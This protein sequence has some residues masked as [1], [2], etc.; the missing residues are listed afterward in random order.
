MTAE[1]SQD[2]IEAGRGYEEL[3]VPALFAPWTEHLVAAAH[4]GEGSHVLDVACGTGVLARRALA[5]VGVAGRVVGV[6]PAPGMIAV[7]KEIEPRIQWIEC[8]AE[9]LQLED[10]AFDC[11]VSQFG[12]MFFDDRPKAAEEM[13][14]VLKKDG[15]LAVAVW[16]T[17]D[18]NPVY[19]DVVALLQEHVS[20]RAAD[21]LRLP[22]SLGNAEEVFD[23][24]QQAGFAGVQSAT[25]FEKGKFRSARQMVEAEL[26]GW[27]PMFDINLEEDEIETVL[28]ASEKVFN[29]YAAHS[30]EI[31]FTTSAHII[32]A[33]KG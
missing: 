20:N 28:A 10:G 14:R 33:Q 2:L 7:A 15:S 21:A 23:C 25:R 3:F 27:L 19:Q 30:G 32:T 6:D 24:V 1:V 4:V 31:E 5:K 18:E 12:M 16:N 8:A 26:R 29:K 13:F 11:V 9:N 17:L 22:F